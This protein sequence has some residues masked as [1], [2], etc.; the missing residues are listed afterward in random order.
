MTNATYRG[1]GYP[2][3]P[4]GAGLANASMA[5]GI[6]A[7]ALPH[8]ADVAQVCMFGLRRPAG[9]LG[10]A[11]TIFIFSMVAA[12]IVSLILGIVALFRMTARGTLRNGMGQATTGIVLSLPQVSLVLLLAISALLGARDF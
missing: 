9:I 8:I 6:A 10:Q 7:V 4:S 5:L 12:A 1:D 11:D 2:T 3:R